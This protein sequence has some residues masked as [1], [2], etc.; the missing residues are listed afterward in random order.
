MSKISD[1]LRELA[2]TPEDLTELPGIINEV[3]KLENNETELMDKVD[4]L[5]E[6]NK[7]YLKMVTVSDP[8]EEISDPDEPE[9]PTLKEL[10]KLMTKEEEK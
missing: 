10:A 7:R 4:K 1:L 6:A 5:H 9:I 8:E 3:E 2:K